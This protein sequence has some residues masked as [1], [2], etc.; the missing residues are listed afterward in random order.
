MQ[1]FIR[2]FIFVMLFTSLPMTSKFNRTLRLGYGFSVFLLAV[3]GLFAYLV[4]QQLLISNRQVTASD[5]A[6]RQ[7]LTLLSVMKD[8]ETGERGYL[9]TGDAQFLE[10]YQ[11]SYERATSLIDSLTLLTRDDASQYHNVIAIRTILLQRLDSLKNLIHKKEQGGSVTKTDLLAGKSA[12]DELRRAVAIAAREEQ[13]ALSRRT[14][15]EAAYARWTPVLL[16]TAVILGVLTAVYAYATIVKDISEKERLRAEVE[17]KEQETAAYNEELTAAN[18]EI[19]AANEELT[20]INE[21]LAEAREELLEANTSLEQR[22]AERTE[23][24]QASEEETQALNEELMAINEELAASNEELTATNEDLAEHERRL[25][26][27]VE[28]LTV[29]EERSSK[30]AAIV[31]SSDDA[32]LSKDFNSVVTSWNQG[33][34][35]M[36]GYSEQEMI[37]RSILTLIPEE[38]QHE[39]P[40]II[41]K[42]RNGERVDHYET[43]RLTKD[44]RLLDVSLTISPV[45]DKQGKITGISKIARDITEPKLIEQ[46]KSDFIG[47]ASH[48]L[49]TPLTSLIALVQVL[50]R[51]S[52]ENGDEFYQ[53]LLDKVYRQTQKMTGLISGFLNVS[54]LESG[55]LVLEQTDFDLPA[56]V[57]EQVGEIRLAVTTHEFRMD[58][59][60]SITIHADREKIGSVITNLLSNAV[61]YSPR[62]KTV[63][64][65]CDVSG[66]EV[67]VSV[68]DQGMGIKPQDLS[69]I[70]DRY[71]RVNSEHMRN[72]SGFGVGLYLSAEIIRQHGGRIW[73]ES[74]KGVGSTFYFAL[75]LSA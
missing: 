17:A 68:R 66:A 70:F 34:E 51:K 62:A 71:Y 53:S 41:S 75:P 61:K 13:L 74:E 19:T 26:N 64:I 11:G 33:A 25:Q 5:L 32:I 18:E 65:N 39:E 20:A 30:L 15:R 56:L 48:E 38:L 50:Q 49:K 2:A 46:R 7:L 6:S 54:R 1:K 35:R 16:L 28:E 52:R 40:V 45:L 63:S 10:P 31:A 47:I 59:C 42:L 69:R 67:L 22:V 55:G 36:F 43:K 9:L 23:A 29:A 24:L 8:A 4:V 58:T 12:M 27:L 72:I 14:A 60:D 3:T 73:V 44:G 21:E 37:G 57:R